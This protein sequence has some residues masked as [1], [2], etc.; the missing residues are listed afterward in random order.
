MQASSAAFPGNPTAALMSSMDQGRGAQAQSLARRLEGFAASTEDKGDLRRAAEDFEAVFVSQMLAPMFQGISTD[1]LFGGG[2]AE[3]VWRSM[4]V[5]EMGKAVA[6][7][8]G[9]GLADSVEAHLLRLQ[10]A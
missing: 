10:E 7:S 4:M 5:D 2:H 9:I 3:Q 8:G 6:A 1:G